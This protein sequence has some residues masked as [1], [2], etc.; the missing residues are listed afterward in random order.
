M[1]TL[2]PV[3]PS[4]SVQNAGLSDRDVIERVRSG[5]VELFEILMRR[6][7]Q[8]VFRVARAVL[9]S[10]AEAE[11]LAQEAWVRAYEHLGDFAGRAAF[12]TWLIRIVL[13]EGWARARRER[14]FEELRP[15]EEG[16]KT[17]KHQAAP[18]GPEAQTLD[19][20]IRTMLEAAVGSLPETYRTVF[21]LRDIE[22]LSTAETA[23]C[24]ELSEEAVKTRLHRARAS[25]RR[26]LLAL[27]GGQ[28]RE[29]FPFLGRRC[30][31]MVE[32]VLG[33][34]RNRPAG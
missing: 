29:A 6:Y 34:I 24:L 4:P 3:M 5:E 30:D 7:N 28:A 33:R 8:R 22:E 25:L 2:Q 15:E 21:V 19:R 26:E 1:E 18:A 27:A 20:E 9:A 12:S 10:D 23:E 32:Q 16:E 11:D 13:H 14:R 17:M 31:R